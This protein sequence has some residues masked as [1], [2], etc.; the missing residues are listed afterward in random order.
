MGLDLSWMV[1]WN[2][3]PGSKYHC[4]QYLF[5]LTS[6]YYYT[7]S[8]YVFVLNESF[9]W[10]Y[11]SYLCERIYSFIHSFYNHFLFLIPIIFITCHVSNFVICNKLMQKFCQIKQN[12]QLLCGMQFL[13]KVRLIIDKYSVLTV[14]QSQFPSISHL[15][16]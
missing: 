16:L 7:S 13:L 3:L 14:T 15:T 10:Y 11:G 9:C 1:H 5:F 12:L 8:N 6:Y 2:D 4:L